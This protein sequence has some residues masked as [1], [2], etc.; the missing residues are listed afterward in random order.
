MA[1]RPSRVQL[2]A[3]LD[4][5]FTEL[6]ERMGGPPRAQSRRRGSGPT[7]GI[8]R[9]TTPPRSRGT[10]S[11]CRQVERAGEGWAVGDKPLREYME[12]QGYGDA[13]RW[14]YAQAMEPGAWTEGNCSL[15]PR[16]DEIH[17]WR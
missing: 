14:V 1:G 3:N 10:R 5:A 16:C 13:A 12:V 17:T 4:D 15:S 9:R 2:Y 8:W 11:C 7:S 6:H